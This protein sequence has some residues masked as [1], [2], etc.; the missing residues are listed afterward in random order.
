V[1]TNCTWN[2]I[3]SLH[4]VGWVVSTEAIPN[5]D[6]QKVKVYPNPFTDFVNFEIVSEAHDLLYKEKQFEL[7]NSSG[8]LIHSSIFA[9][10]I[11]RF[12]KNRLPKGIYYYKIQ[13]DGNAINSGKLIIQ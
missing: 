10:T 13:Q 6:I 7:Y 3:G 11:Y 1:L 8:Q 9:D 2:T 4:E 12:H 5:V